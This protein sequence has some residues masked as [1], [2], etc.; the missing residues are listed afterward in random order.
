MDGSDNQG[1]G[2]SRGEE[3][4]PIRLAAQT[5]RTAILKLQCPRQ[6]MIRSAIRKPWSP[7]RLTARAIRI[8]IPMILWSRHRSMA[9][10]IKTA[11][12]LL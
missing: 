1:C 6:L 10:T 4:V 7:R 3:G 5:T 11:S 8:A 12:L 2:G 9:R